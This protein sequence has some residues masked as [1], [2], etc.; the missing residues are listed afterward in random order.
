MS[1][2]IF[3]SYARTDDRLPP[4]LQDGKGF[5]TCLLEQTYFEFQQLGAPWP[6]IWRDTRNLELGDVF[7]PIIEEAIQQSDLL[8]VVLSP[9]WMESE[10]CR[11]ELD[12]FKRRWQQEGELRL[13]QR[14]V[15]ACKRFVDRGKRPSLLQ[16][17]PGYDF[18]AFDGPGETGSQFDY[19]ARGV[20]RDK[21]YDT[22]VEGLAGFLYRR[23][24]Q[25]IRPN[26]VPPARAPAPPISDIP[27]AP[28]PNPDARKIYLAKPASDMRE[29]YSRLVQELSR[30]GYAIVPDPRLEIPFDASATGFIDQA[31]SEADVS[32]HLLGDK[33]GYTPEPE[34]PA[35]E[36]EPIVK[37]Q[38]GRAQAR[39]NRAGD[40][41]T[42]G[43]QPVFERLIWA[44]EAIGDG[45]EQTAPRQGT[46][47][48]GSGAAPEEKRQPMDIL[49]KFGPF[50]PSSDK[51]LGNNLSK[52][53][54]FVVDHLQRSDTSQIDTSKLDADSW[55]YVYHQVEDANY[56]SEIAKAMRQRGIIANLPA[57]EGDAG[58][59]IRLHQK[60]LAE[61]SAV[62][63]CWAKASEVWARMRANEL[64]WKKLGRSEKFAYRGLLACPPPGDGKARF[65]DVPPL[66]EIDITVDATKGERPMAEV[67]EPFVNLA[68]PH[69]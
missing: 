37:L 60:Y 55:V 35:A 26:I 1:I 57:L 11:Q 63:L 19:F 43:S 10:Y 52:F 64:N 2:Q 48:N 31:L 47:V 3:L 44:P 4:N 5:V 17:Q 30:N 23:A 32:I 59:L 25:I 41:T 39:V 6:T 67:I 49:A 14:L 61:C 56:A 13:K 46:S 24:Q 12:S 28:P 62:V 53:V 22:V 42:A 66:N 38:L 51:V 8:L 29:A 50:L 34:N 15:V 36:S 45:A 16:G 54:D 20:I 68:R 40:A 33:V 65:V 9:N 58:E 69:A 27:A 7:D 21:R 18:F